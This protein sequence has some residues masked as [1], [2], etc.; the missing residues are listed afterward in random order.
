MVIEDIHIMGLISFLIMLL[1]AAA[2]AWIAEMLVPGSIPG[3]FLVSA[4][5]GL[6]GAW[7]GSSLFGAFGPS[8]EGVP[9]IPCILGTA[10]LIFLLRLITRRSVK[11]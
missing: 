8:L 11:V 3:G 2:C 5:V 6:I 10:I 9:L 7:V 4:I 1:V